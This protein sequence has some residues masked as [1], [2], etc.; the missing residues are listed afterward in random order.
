[1][2]SSEEEDAFK[3]VNSL[4]WYSFRQMIFYISII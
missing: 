1:M 4:K 2:E 3:K